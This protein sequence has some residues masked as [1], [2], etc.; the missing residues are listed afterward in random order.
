MSLS[1]QHHCRRAVIFA[2]ALAASTA[3]VEAQS[4]YADAAK[5]YAGTTIRVLDEITP[6]RKSVV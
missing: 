1:W 3:A 2:A 4:F 6:D 5:P